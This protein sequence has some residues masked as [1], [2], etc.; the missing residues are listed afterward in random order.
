MAFPLARRLVLPALLLLLAAPV[1]AQVVPLDGQWFKLSVRAQGRT[2]NPNLTLKKGSLKTKCFLHLTHVATT[3]TGVT[4]D[5]ELWTKQDGNVWAPSG[6]G[7]HNFIGAAAGDQLAANLPLELVLADGKSLSVRATLFFNLKVK[8][9]TAQ[10]KKVH[11]STLGGETIDGSVNGTD[12]FAGG[13]VVKGKGVATGKLP[14][15]P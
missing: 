2:V 8:K 13:A 3:A 10:L 7:Q 9:G 1:T 15:D 12:P 14:F 4:Y 11:V 6:T 5:W